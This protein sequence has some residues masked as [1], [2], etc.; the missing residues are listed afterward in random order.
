MWT[1]DHAQGQDDWR[2]SCKHEKKEKSQYLALVY[3]T[4]VNSTFR[5]R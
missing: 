1:I 3:T 2:R 4:Q 5:A